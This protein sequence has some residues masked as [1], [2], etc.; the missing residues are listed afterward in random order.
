MIRW[1]CKEPGWWILSEGM[2][3]LAAV[4]NEAIIPKPWCVYIDETMPPGDAQ[5]R[6]LREAKAW[7]EERTRKADT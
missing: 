7:A 1:E 3:K 2:V 5:F 4:C 6:T